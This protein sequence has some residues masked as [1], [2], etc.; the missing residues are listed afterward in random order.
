MRFRPGGSMHSLHLLPVAV[1]RLLA[2]RPWIYWLVV[3]VA[4]IGCGAEVRQRVGQVEHARDAW[5]E[6]R[7]VLVARHDTRAG[8]ALDVEVRR[9]PVTV[10]PVSALRDDPNRGAL[11]ARQ[12]VSAGEIVTT[13]DVGR[14]G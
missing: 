9:V 7:D 8:E 11:T 10:V 12:D 13:V 4:A 2:R 5:G 14:A 1:R 6:A 3:F